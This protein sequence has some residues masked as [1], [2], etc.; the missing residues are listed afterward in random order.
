MATV[1][2]ARQLSLDRTVAIMRRTVVASATDPNL[3]IGSCP[4]CTSSISNSAAV[5]G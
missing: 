5:S 2:K 3:S 1:F 4:P